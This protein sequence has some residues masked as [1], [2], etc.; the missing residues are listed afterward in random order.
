MSVSARHRREVPAR[1]H[2]ERT[3]RGARLV[4]HQ[5][6]AQL[7]AAA[8][9]TQL[10]QRLRLYLTNPLAR[11]VE[12]L[13]DF[14][15][16]MV[17]VHIDAEPHAEH[18][19][20][21]RRQLRQ[22]RMRGLAQRFG[23]RRINRRRHRR[24]LD[25]IAQVRILI[26]ADRG[27][28]RNRLFRDLE[29]FA[30]LVL[31]HLHADGQFLRRRFAAHFLQ[32]LPRNSIQ[33]V[34]RFD[35]VHRNADGARLVR[36]RAGDGL[37]YP[38]SRVGRELVSAAIFE[39]VD[40]LHQADVAFLDQVEELQSAIGVFLG[41][42][43]DET[44]IGLDHFLLGTPRLRLA[45]G[46][47]AIDLLDLADEN[48]EQA[49]EVLELVLA[50]LDFILEL[51]ERSRV[52][53]L[54][55]YVLIEPTRAGFVLRKRRNEIL[56]RH[57]GLL[58]AQEHDLLLEQTDFGHVLAEIVDQLIEHL[59]G[60]LQFHQLAA[61][62]LANLLRLGVLRSQLV[63]RNQELMMDLR[64]RKEALGRLFGIGTGVDRFLVLIAIRLF[65]VVGGLFSLEGHHFRILGLGNLVRRVGIDEADDDVDQAHLTRLYRF[66]VPQQQIVGAGV[67]AERYFY[68]LQALFDALR[69]ANFAL[70]SQQLHGAH[71][72]HV[73]A[74]RIGGA[75]ELGVE[76]C[77]RCGSFLDRLLVRRSGGIGQQ[78]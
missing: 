5:E 77:E 17:G 42:R 27:F 34:D 36:D 61:D 2:R 23:G 66:V 57:P 75:A 64:E 28:H 18:F 69:D 76:I 13:A 10:A 9:V 26:V 3:G 20:L 29:N 24:V 22:H 48:V 58:D 59:R 25:E 73:H 60:E 47:L 55:L 38:P 14:L 31:R 6:A 19:R 12:L 43:D 39:L 65:L 72:A 8:G 30:Y 78:Q 49:L 1:P 32:H 21:S 46:H 71:L 45:D 44:Q 74:H 63:E 51:R 68:G 16:S 37:T 67:A 15:E 62:L 41:D 50:A 53:F 56:A 70:A 4:V 11:H 35:H 33:L 54:G 40:G 7:L 52:A